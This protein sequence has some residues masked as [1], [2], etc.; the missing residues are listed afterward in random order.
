LLLGAVD[1]H[2]LINCRVGE[3]LQK[4]RRFHH[5][6]TVGVRAPEGIDVFANAAPDVG[7]HEF[8]QFLNPVRLVEDAL[9][10]ALA[11]DLSAGVAKVLPEF[12]EHGGMRRP[13]RSKRFMPQHIGIHKRA[14]FFFEAPG[15]GAL[16][17]CQPAG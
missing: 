2:N 6:D 5:Q 4:Q 11:V 16:T 9:G 3:G 7:V 10:Q 14:A 17:A 12:G 15:H 13:A 1:R 8:I